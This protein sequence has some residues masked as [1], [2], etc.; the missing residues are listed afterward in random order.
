MSIG[1]SR[2]M[3]DIDIQ[4]VYLG[5]LKRKCSAA[6]YEV[7][8]IYRVDLTEADNITYTVEL[9]GGRRLCLP[10]EKPCLL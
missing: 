10:M 3:I 8:N 2:G 4:E 9:T 5:I 6:A 7:Y 1:V